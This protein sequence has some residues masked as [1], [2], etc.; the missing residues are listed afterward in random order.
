MP[1][2]ERVRADPDLIVTALQQKFLEP[3]PMGEPA[4]RVAPASPSGATRI[5]IGRASCRERVCL[6][7]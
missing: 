6:Y 4:I 1:E 3:D 2:I 5:E 7:V